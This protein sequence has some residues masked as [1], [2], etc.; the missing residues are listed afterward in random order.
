M[1]GMR[2]DAKLGIIQDKGPSE[3]MGSF[4]PNI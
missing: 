2:I 4:G 3:K 1:E